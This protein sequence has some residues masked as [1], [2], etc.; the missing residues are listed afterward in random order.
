[1]KRT[2]VLVTLVLLL[3]TALWPSQG[4]E[5][6]PLVVQ[7]TKVS[8]A[9]VETEQY[10][11][12]IVTISA[13]EACKAKVAKE[14]TFAT[15]S[16]GKKHAITYIHMLSSERTSGAVSGF[17][18]MR[19]I[20]FKLG[21]KTYKCFSPFGTQAIQLIDDESALSVSFDKNS[22]IELALLFK[23][24]PRLVKSITI[25]GRE[26]S[27]KQGQKGAPPSRIAFRSNRDGN[28]EIYVINQDGS[29]LKRLTSNTFPDDQPRFSPDGNK[30]VF[31]SDRSGNQDIYI[32]NADGSEQNRLTIDPAKDSEP[33]FSPDGSRVV[34]ASKRDGDWRIYLMNADGSQQRRLSDINGGGPRY[35]PDGKRIAFSS[36][37]DGTPEIYVMNADGNN[38]ARLTNNTTVD[39]GP[40]FSADGKSIVFTAMI[41][42][43]IEVCQ[44][45]AGGGEVKNLSRNPAN[46]GAPCYTPDG[47]FV[48]FVS[49]RNGELALYIMKAD[50]SEPKR[51]SPPQASDAMPHVAGM[52]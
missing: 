25:L 43:N 47:K 1:M 13:T 33:A 21:D 36:M 51:L 39:S 38:H 8:E 22:K 27:S 49:S 23:G 20:R 11:G 40:S 45:P 7:L 34:F 29:Q 42:R 30:I 28:W 5:Q 19:G 9:S 15:A 48:I 2:L 32:M 50:G 31:R 24:D 6:L 52:P 26:L 35:S 4:A 44:I 46:D 37:K 41:G 17:A 10:I 14:A 12:A 16:D 3:G 18:A